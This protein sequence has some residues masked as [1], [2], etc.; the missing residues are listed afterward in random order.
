MSISEI[1]VPRETVVFAARAT[2]A[3]EILAIIGALFG[4]AA[5]A[6]P[7]YLFVKIFIIG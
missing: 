6:I 3:A 1:K 4:L 7:I 5:A 2:M